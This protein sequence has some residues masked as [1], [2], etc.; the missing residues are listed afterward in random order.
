MSTGLCEVVT[1]FPWT[2]RYQVISGA[3]TRR[4]ADPLGLRQ[5]VNHLEVVRD[6]YWAR[7]DD[8]PLTPFGAGRSIQRPDR[9]GLITGADHGVRGSTTLLAGTGRVRIAR[10]DRAWRSGFGAP[11]CRDARKSCWRSTVTGC[12]RRPPL[13]RPAHRRGAPHQLL[14]QAERRRQGGSRDRA[15]PSAAGL[16]PFTPV[17]PR[18]VRAPGRRSASART[19]HSPAACGTCW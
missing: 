1:S 16:S 8:R 7:P 19:C 2:F 6:E 3:R 18:S 14:P 13:R 15:F 9:Q 12:G 5:P 17:P 10:E 4:R 11:R